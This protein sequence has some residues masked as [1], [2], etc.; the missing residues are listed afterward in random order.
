MF[1]SLFVISMLI[2]QTLQ[3]QITAHCKIIQNLN[4]GISG[5]INFYQDAS[6]GPVEINAVV[7]GIPNIHGFHIHEKPL[8]NDNCDSA[9]P[10]FNPK[11]VTHGG[12]D[13]TV[14]HV[15]DLGNIVSSGKNETDYSFTDQIITLIPNITNSVV[16]RSCVIH[17]S[18][19]DLGLGLQDSNKTGNAGKRIGCGTIMPG[20]NSF[21]HQLAVFSLAII[22]IIL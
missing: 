2:A 13:A 15:G 3:D 21:M 20:L 14:R 10:H 16:G 12:P 19:D 18:K 11:N 22:G 9:G 6:G 7:Y 8:E 5:N 4:S 1:K 17:E